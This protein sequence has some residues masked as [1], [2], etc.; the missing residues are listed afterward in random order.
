MDRGL[1]SMLSQILGLVMAVAWTMIVWIE[2]NVPPLTG[3]SMV[4]GLVRAFVSDRRLGTDATV[5]RRVPA[6]GPNC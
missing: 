3:W 1:D 2:I 4:G 6:L 5:L